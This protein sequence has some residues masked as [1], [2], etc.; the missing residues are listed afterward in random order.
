MKTIMRANMMPISVA[1]RLKKSVI[2]IDGHYFFRSKNNVYSWSMPYYK[3]RNSCCWEGN[4]RH[5]EDINFMR[6]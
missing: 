1:S 4:Q 6:F 2:L 3:R 5:S